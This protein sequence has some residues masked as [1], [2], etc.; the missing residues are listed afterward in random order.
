MGYL[1]SL[2]IPTNGVSEWVFPVLDSI[3]RDNVPENLFEVVVTDNGNN[4]AFESQVI[5][6][7]K[8]HSNL[9]YQKTTSYMFNNQL[10][11]FRLAT[12]DLIKF[13]NHRSLL[14]H[15]SLQ[16]LI[17]VEKKYRDQRPVIFLLNESRKTNESIMVC[18]N[19]DEFV[20]KLS[21]WSSW[22]GGLSM[23]KEDFRKIP[24]GISVDSFFPHTALLFYY[25]NKE[26]YIIDNTS[27]TEDIEADVTKKGKYNLFEAFA[28]YYP[29]L[30]LDLV[31]KKDISL[32]T[33]LSVKDDNLDFL[34]NLYLDYVVR[35]KP[36]S[37]SLDDLS[38]H[39]SVFYS[40]DEVK[41]NVRKLILHKAVHKLKIR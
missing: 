34:S 13:I 40:L 27:L 23:W 26:Q 18:K 7:S 39:L 9:K 21:Y 15:G 1:V 29:A 35:K 16:Y 24:E 14:K 20:Q 28:E 17:E 19:F 2:C 25:R 3:Y 33:F 22:S 4:Q 38:D 41:K 10:D 11:A 37:Y 5:D 31:H 32:N 36:C 6:V 8:K 12:G 30:L